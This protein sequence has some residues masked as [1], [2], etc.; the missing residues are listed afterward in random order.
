MA[1]SWWKSTLY[2]S[3]LY[4][5]ACGA[6]VFDANNK[7]VCL[8][9]LRR[10]GEWVLPKGR[11][12]CHETRQEAACREVREESGY[13]IALVPLTLPTRA[14]AAAEPPDVKDVP[15]VYDAVVE[16]F[17]LDIRDLDQKGVKLVWWFV[18]EL[19]DEEDAVRGGKGRGEDQFRPEWVD[20]R[21]AVQRLTFQRDRD[22]LARAVE[23]V[24]LRANININMMRDC[25]YG[26]IDGVSM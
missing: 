14:P 25:D 13:D 26:S 9:N 3:E 1:E 22:V 2:P 7:K 4:V 19:E 11:R 23:L 12:N 16:P 15:R 8:L 18:A 10:T 6:I 20:A 5:E 17:M 21:E 24:K